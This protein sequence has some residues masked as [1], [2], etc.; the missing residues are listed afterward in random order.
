MAGSPSP[1]AAVLNALGLGDATPEPLPTGLIN[2]SWLIVTPAGQPLVLQR[3]N[4]I[5]PT[6]INTDI[7]VVTRHLAAQGL[8]T[9]RLI[10]TPDGQLCLEAEGTVW[11]QLTYIPGN[12]YDILGNSHQAGE[13]GALLGRFHRAVGELE[14]TFSNAR[15]G[16]HDTVRHL[17]HLR[18]TLNRSG[19]HPRFTEVRALAEDVFELANGLPDL[20]D[21]PDRIVHGDPKI[22]NIVFAEESDDALCLI[23][24]DTLGC[25][26]IVLELGDAFRSW[27]N[28][29]AED[30]PD[31]EFSLPLFKSAIAGYARETKGFLTENEWRQIPAATLTI[32]VELAARFCADALTESYFGWNA[33][34][35][36]SASDHNQA[37]TR[38][39]IELAHSISAQLEQMESAVTATFA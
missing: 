35:F 24:L 29:H 4:P 36:A 38:N 25:M 30:E 32:T 5:F 1:S 13:A 14:H 11:R 16:V 9:P 15:P 18:A 22:S 21:T 37:R 7:D 12:T 39:Q 3:V 19:N 20:G 31:A 2:Q 6:A 23:D 8:R 27:C 28:P 33:A 17:A 34:R 10:P 26:P